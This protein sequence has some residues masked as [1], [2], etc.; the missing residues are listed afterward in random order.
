M[1]HR[2]S[3]N[4]LVPPNLKQKHNGN[5]NI[6]SLTGNESKT[7]HFSSGTDVEP[8]H[9]MVD[10]NQKEKS[11][12]ALVSSKY[13]QNLR[14]KLKTLEHPLYLFGASSGSIVC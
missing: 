13:F 8:S 14:R 1:V 11:D 4:S 6:I 3:I 7:L 9:K 5:A 12:W 10:F 2:T